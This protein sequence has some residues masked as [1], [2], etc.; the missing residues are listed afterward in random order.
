MA[1]PRARRVRTAGAD[2]AQALLGAGTLAWRQGDFAAARVHLDESVALWRDTADRRGQAE[3]LHVLGHVEFDQRDYAAAQALFEESLA[4]YQLAADTPGSLPLMADLGLVAYHRGDYAEAGAV[5]EESLAQFRRHGLKDRVAGALN[6]LGDLARLAGDQDRAAALYEREP[7]VVARAAR[8][9]G[10]RLRPAQAR[11]GEAVHRRPG[12]RRGRTSWRASPSSRTWATPRE[13]RSAWPGSA[14]RSRPRAGRTGRPGSSPRARRSWSRSAFRWLPPIR[15][16]WSATWRRP[17][18][19]WA[20]R[21]GSRRGRR[22]TPCRRT[23]PSSSPLADDT[24]G[25]APVPRGD[26]TGAR[27]RPCPGGN[28]R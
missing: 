23:R 8:H 4:A 6:V 11:A 25:T 17:G 12:R 2:R 15:P 10:D 27:R 28:A 21:S 7:G 3:A 19:D 26:R 20:P 24:G 18:S 1:H 13:S 22:D 16:R 5:F 9:A 14:G